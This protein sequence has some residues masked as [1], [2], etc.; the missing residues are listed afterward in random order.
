MKKMIIAVGGGEIGRIKVLPDGTSVQTDVETTLIDRFI[1]DATGK[2]HPKMLFVGTA[3]GDKKSYLEVVENHFKGRLGCHSVEPLNL[4]EESI[5]I[6]EIRNKIFSSDII[7]VGGGDTTTMLNIWQKYKLG[8][9]LYEAYQK[10]IVLAGISAGAI[11]WFEYYDNMDDIENIEQLD[12]VRGLGFI[13][14]FGVPHYDWLTEDEKQRINDKLKQK[15]I[16]GWSMDDCTALVFQ[17]GSIKIMTCRDDR[18]VK[19]IP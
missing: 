7:Y 9:I 1:V 3:S 10:G 17:D 8:D 12:L 18:K 16:Q 13:K 11:C 14:G 19:Q 6:Q 2:K 5:S 15:N 4:V